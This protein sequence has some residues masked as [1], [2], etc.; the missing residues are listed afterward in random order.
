MF[1]IQMYYLTQVFVPLALSFIFFPL[2]LNHIHIFTQ[3]PQIRHFLPLLILLILPMNSFPQSPPP[4]TKEFQPTPPPHPLPNLTCF[5]FMV[6]AK[7]PYHF[8]LP[9]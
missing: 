3:Q 7:P 5:T 1:G 2:F 9:P 8:N 6:L 4:W